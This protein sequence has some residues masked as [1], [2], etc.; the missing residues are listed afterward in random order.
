MGQKLDRVLSCFRIG[1]PVG[2]HEIFSAEGS[3]L[4]PG[5][6]N[7]RKS[8][9]ICTSEHYSTA[10]LEKLVHGSG[11]LPPN[12]HY[13]RITI[14]PT[15]SYEVFQ[16]EAHSGW[17][18][19]RENICKKFGEAWHQEGRSAILLVPSIQARLEN[20]N[21]LNPSHPKFGQITWELAQPVWWD[22]RLYK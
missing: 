4:Y 21:L 14:P 22:S 3:S 8:P 5:R 12:Q 6:W 10:M 17:D 9:M 7:T 15:V 1:D 20:N 11:L 18:G 13:I 2:E 19:P 16:P